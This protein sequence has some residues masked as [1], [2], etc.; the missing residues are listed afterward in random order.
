MNILLAET[1]HFSPAALERLEAVATV[2]QDFEVDLA[3]CEV[4]WVRLA[5]KIDAGVMDRAPA[6]KAI[7]SAISS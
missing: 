3:D 5:R 1:E 7:V 2:G 6:L 4:L